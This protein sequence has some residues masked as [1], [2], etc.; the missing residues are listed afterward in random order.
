MSDEAKAVLRGKFI[1]L[2]AYVRK[3]ER[4]KINNLS[5]HLRKLKKSE[6]FKSEASNTYI[7]TYEK[8]EE[9]STNLKP[10]KQ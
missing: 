5:F 1:A 3:H 6:Q 7:Q 9:K 8:L 2:N 10:E 4:S